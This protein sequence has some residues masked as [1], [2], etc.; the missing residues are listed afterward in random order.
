MVLTDF[1]IIHQNSNLTE[2]D[3]IQWKIPWKKSTYRSFIPTEQLTDE[4]RLLSRFVTRTIQSVSTLPTYTISRDSD[5]T[6]DS[7]FDIKTKY[8]TG[9]QE[10]KVVEMDSEFQDVA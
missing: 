3:E 2:P 10:G 4:E 1:K 8:V 9:D 6:T 5:R 7:Q